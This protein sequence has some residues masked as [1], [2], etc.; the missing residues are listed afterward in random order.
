MLAVSPKTIELEALRREMVV[1]RPNLRAFAMSLCGDL[2]RADDLAQ[3]TMLR[4]MTYVDQF[5][6]GT[7]MAAWLFTILRN[8]FRSECRKRKREVEDVAGVLNGVEPREGIM[9]TVPARLLATEGEG[10]A[11]AR[12]D[13]ETLRDCLERLPTAQREA[14]TLVAI[15]GHSYEDA[16]E[17]L[18][19][20]VGTVKSRV[21][22]ARDALAAMMGGYGE[23]IRADPP[24]EAPAEEAEAWSFVVASGALD[25][26]ADEGGM[27]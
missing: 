7:N 9:T 6:P 24:P 17:I 4:A 15:S 1:L 25:E 16:A 3:T 11:I 12:L 26:F 5:T 10:A 14:L 2:D 18:G 21:N 27:D 20:E 8:H 23:G 19:C 13:H 22:R